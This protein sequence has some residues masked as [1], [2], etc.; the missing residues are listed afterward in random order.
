MLMVIGIISLLLSMAAPTLVNSMR[1]ATLENSTTHI[2]NAH[3]PC[4]NSASGDGSLVAIY[5][6]GSTTW[7][8]ITTGNASTSQEPRDR[9]LKDSKGLVFRQEIES[10][11][12]ISQAA[13]PHILSSY[14]ANWHHRKSTEVG[15]SSQVLLAWRPKT[16]EVIATPGKA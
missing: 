5:Q 9:L 15:A 10:P 7:I 4:V 2:R 6:Q 13:L 3:S 16:W 1:D 11:L 12:F 8:A 14:C